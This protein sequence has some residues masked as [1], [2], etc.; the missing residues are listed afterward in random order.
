MT[1]KIYII[2]AGSYGEAIADLAEH[3]GYQI[4]GYYDDDDSKKD[5]ICMGA[6]V[7]GKI[8]ISEE[9]VSGKLFAIAIGNN[10][11]RE[12]IAGKIL[13]CGGV[14]P[15][16]IHST[17]VISKQVSIGTGCFVHA[18]SF[19]WTKV[20]VADF[21]IISPQ[22]VLAHHSEMLQSSFVSAGSNVGANI[23]IGQRAFI[24]IGSTLMTGINQI[25]SDSVVG[26]GSVV[27]KDVNNGVT[28]AGNP[29]KQIKK[30]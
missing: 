28:V 12:S 15:S 20:S 8:E 21:C 30:S 25:G 10:K 7:I 13:D 17:V 24:G 22:V 3:C 5:T 23:K 9:K 2:G 27:I 11:I 29:A 18:Q 16:L 19:L 26:A 6:K 14:L 1:K 4:A